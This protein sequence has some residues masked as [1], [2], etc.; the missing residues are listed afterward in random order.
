MTTENYGKAQGLQ[1]AMNTLKQVL[2]VIPTLNG[3][4]DPEKTA[5][6]TYVQHLHDSV[7]KQFNDL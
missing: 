3:L 5:F 4:T 7:Q 2:N 6:Q 1:N